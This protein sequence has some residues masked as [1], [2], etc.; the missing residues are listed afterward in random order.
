MK[1]LFSLL[2][3]LL[4]NSVNASNMGDISYKVYNLKPNGC[5]IITHAYNTNSDWVKKTAD[6][7]YNAGK[8]VITFDFPGHGNS[9]KSSN[10]LLP[11]MVESLNKLMLQF[12]LKTYN[13]VAWS[14]SADVV[15]HAMHIGVLPGLE[16]LVLVATALIDLEKRN[17][18]AAARSDTTAI[19]VQDKSYAFIKELT[20]N[21]K[22]MIVKA[23]LCHHDT[24]I[25]DCKVPEAFFNS[26][27]NTDNNVRSD[28]V[29]SYFQGDFKDEFHILKN[30]KEV[31]LCFFYAEYDAL[32][33]PKYMKVVANL[34]NADFTKS[35]ETGHSILF[36]DPEGMSNALNECFAK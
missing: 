36:E 29:Q 32:L 28:T 11:S 33:N 12:K 24:P 17:L 19:E 18:P 8:C 25:N 16:N 30:R 26:I 21:N 7:L 15:M 31:T 20:K 13:I 35:F 1:N 10:Y 27:E 34:V 4:V 3:L 2:L 6:I 23:M 22:L 14:D 9:D 5:T